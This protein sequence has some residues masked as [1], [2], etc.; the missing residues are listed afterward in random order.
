MKELLRNLMELIGLL[1]MLAWIVAGL[2]L[3]F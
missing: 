3:L 1:A 2:V